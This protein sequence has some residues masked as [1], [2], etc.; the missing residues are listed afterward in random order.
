MTKPV[1]TALRRAAPAPLPIPAPTA[2]APSTAVNVRLPNDVV[3]LLDAH[4]AHLARDRPGT[5]VTRSDALRA[6]L[7][8]GLA[9]LAPSEPSSVRSDLGGER[10]GPR[11]TPSVRNTAPT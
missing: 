7:L 8:Q 6:V 3:D 10:S 5:K 9:T 11:S 2:T 1:P 4:A